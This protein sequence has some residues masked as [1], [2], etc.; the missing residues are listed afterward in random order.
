MQRALRPH[1]TRVYQVSESDLHLLTE[2][3]LIQLGVLPIGPRRRI[4]MLL[5]STVA[6]HIRG[7]SCHHRACAE[8]L[9]LAVP[10]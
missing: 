8:S 3:D 5:A 6:L 4:V 7:H 9:D 2:D 10:G 1:L